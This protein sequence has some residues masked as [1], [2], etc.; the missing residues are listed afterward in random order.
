MFIPTCII[1]VES[2]AQIE[3]QRSVQ[4]P[5]SRQTWPHTDPTSARCCAPRRRVYSRGAAAADSIIPLRRLAPATQAKP[6]GGKPKQIPRHLFL[7]SR[8]GWCE[9]HCCDENRA[10]V[11]VFVG[12]PLNSLCSR[13]RP[14][15]PKAALVTKKRA[16][17]SSQ[18]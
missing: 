3:A 9:M 16:S 2:T 4:F 12:F 7:V 15:T 5:R 10:N 8:R 1:T 14:F 17:A 6:G 13:V 11:A 18:G